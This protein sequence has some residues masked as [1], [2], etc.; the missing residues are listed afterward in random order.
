VTDSPL[1]LL[2]T[3]LSSHRPPPQ[4]PGHRV[5]GVGIW[6]WRGRANGVH[7][8][9]SCARAHTHTRTHVSYVTKPGLRGLQKAERAIP[10]PGS[11]W[12]L[13]WR[14]R[15]GGGS[16]PHR[17][18]APRCPSESEKFRCRTRNLRTALS[19]PPSRTSSRPPAA[20]PGRSANTASPHPP[21][22][23]PRAGPRPSGRRERPDGAED[24][25]RILGPAS[26]LHLLQRER[27]AGLPARP[28]PAPAPSHPPAPS[29]RPR[30]G[31]SGRVPES[32]RYPN[33]APQT[34]RLRVTRGH[35][36]PSRRNLP[37]MGACAKR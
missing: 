17:R 6:G 32:P 10:A 21:G 36:P 19:P 37:E 3:T 29:P 20:L 2:H 13:P 27:R 26:A 11:R 30:P 23:C 16:R 15:S 24:E 14:D 22:L 28:R 7:L 18:K 12:D 4:I 35:S 1:R 5:G 33:P 25:R 8:A 31:L 34:R 9:R